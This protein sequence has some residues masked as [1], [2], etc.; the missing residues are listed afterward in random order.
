M[1]SAE[2]LSPK[3]ELLLQLSESLRNWDEAYARIAGDAEARG[4]RMTEEKMRV[5]VRNWMRGENQAIPEVVRW[6][7]R[8]AVGGVE[9]HE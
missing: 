2:P 1:S 8:L 3:A 6:A 7:L 9:T 4:I 5:A